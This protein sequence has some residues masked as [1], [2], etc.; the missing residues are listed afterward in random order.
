MAVKLIDNKPERTRLFNDDLEAALKSNEIQASI[1]AVDGLDDSFLR[2][3][4]RAHENQLWEMVKQQEAELIACRDVLRRAK[5]NE[6]FYSITVWPEVLRICIIITMGLGIFSF[7]DS[8]PGSYGTVSSRPHLVVASILAGLSLTFGLISSLKPNRIFQ[9]LA[10]LLFAA[11]MAIFWIAVVKVHPLSRHEVRQPNDQL[12]IYVIWLI[13]IPITIFPFVRWRRI[14][15]PVSAGYL[16]IELV[17]ALLAEAGFIVLPVISFVAGA[18]HA[19]ITTA[20][21]QPVFAIFTILV[22]FGVFVTSAIGL[23]WQP[24]Y[25]LRENCD[26][27]EKKVHDELF[28]GSIMPYLR[29]AISERYPSYEIE[30][31]FSEAPGLSESFDPIYEVRTASRKRIEQVLE[32]M[33]SGGSIGIAGSRG[34]GKS[35]LLASYCGD[36]QETSDGSLLVLLSAPVEYSSRDFLLHMYAT[37][38]RK[39]IESSG[40]QQSS[41][42]LRQS[43][44]RRQTVMLVTYGVLL[45]VVGTFLIMLQTAGVEI[46]TA[47]V[48]GIIIALLG[49]GFAAQGF[50]R[51]HVNGVV[52]KSKDPSGRV[53]APE[54]VAEE[55]LEEIRFQQTLSATWSGTVKTPVGIEG[56][57]GMTR[58]LARQTLLMP[59]IV[60]SLRNFLEAI[61]KTRRV[62]IGID[63]LDKIESDERARQF[64]NEIKGIFGIKGCYFLVS[65]SEEAIGSFER[66]GIPFRDVF[67]SSFDEIVRIRSLGQRDAM[68][69]L[70]RRVARLPIC[71][72]KLAYCLSG[73]L[74]RDLIRAT[75]NIVDTKRIASKPSISVVAKKVISKDLEG[76]AEAVSTAITA[77]DAEPYASNFLIWLRRLRSA[78]LTSSNLESSIK[79]IETVAL[80]V[81]EDDK[82]RNGRQSSLTRLA[83]EFVGYCYYVLTIL[84]I[85]GSDEEWKVPDVASDSTPNEVPD[86]TAYRTLDIDLLTYGRLM[87]SVNTLLAWQII[88]DFR[89]ACGLNPITVPPN[90]GK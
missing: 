61:G 72:Q 80:T 20:W 16:R 63:E 86:V 75:R 69:L 82:D 64:V 81:E 84:D 1:K 17:N 21:P 34:V 8:T 83:R 38:C 55:R 71:F 57:F 13:L 49:G 24:L 6:P 29:S 42:F 47:Q 5:A 43:H 66:R 74:P 31:D 54:E 78:D 85:F 89:E 28:R 53:P 3:Q 68:V 4:C 60:D 76:K 23:K 77:I 26:R 48:W 14:G 51:M 41:D 40:T 45:F 33:P 58:S 88:S 15:T 62:I 27:A 70:N 37:V 87:F 11:A 22:G 39:V 44:A 73:G 2:R 65:V 19:V 35:T 67:D 46:G 32:V 79:S 90:L 25:V 30:L 52:F 50:L 9:R 56:A 18:K 7:F 36:L 59:E 10:V 12:L